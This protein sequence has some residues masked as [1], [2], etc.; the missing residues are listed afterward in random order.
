MIVE[1]ERAPGYTIHE[2]MRRDGV[3]G[4]SIAVID[5]GAV[6]WAEGYGVKRSGRADPVDASTL[7]QAGSVSKAV[8]AGGGPGGGTDPE[9]GG[10]RA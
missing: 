5:D 7:F 4:A 3:P 10:A 1:G 6:E 9:G 2:G 8:A